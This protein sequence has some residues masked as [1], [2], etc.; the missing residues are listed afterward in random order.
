MNLH[1]APLLMVTRSLIFH[2]GVTLNAFFFFF[3]LNSLTQQGGH[4]RDNGC[5][6]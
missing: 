6:E 2:A 1:E 3:F 4:K 5:T